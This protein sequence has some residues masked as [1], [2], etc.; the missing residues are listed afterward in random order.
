[1]GDHSAEQG[2]MAHH[3]R[4]VLGFPAMIARI[5]EK[6]DEDRPLDRDA[7]GGGAIV[8]KRERPAQPRCQ[9]GDHE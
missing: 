1:M 6:L 7:A 4:G 5:D 3:L 8:A 9:A 2:V